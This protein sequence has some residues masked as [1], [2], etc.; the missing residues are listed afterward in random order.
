MKQEKG[1]TYALPHM[2]AIV[3]TLEQV[4]SKLHSAAFLEEDTSEVCQD[5]LVQRTKCIVL[6]PFQLAGAEGRETKIHKVNT[7]G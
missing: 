1:P 3:N 7:Q 4:V 2:D 6:P 5:F